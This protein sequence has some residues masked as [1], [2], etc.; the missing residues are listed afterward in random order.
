MITG[1]A[2]STVGCGSEHYTVYFAAAFDH[3][4]TS[5]G[6]WAGRNVNQHATAS[7]SAQSGAFVT[8]GT[9]SIQVLHVQVGLSFVSIANAR[10]NLLAENAN[11]HFDTV[12]TQADAA[13]NAKLNTIQVQGGTADE[14]RVFYT[15]LYHVFLEPSIFSDVNGQYLGFDN[16]VHTVARGHLH[17]QNIPGWD[18]YRS[19]I[20]LLSIIDASDASD[21]AQSL[22]DDATQGDG[23]IPRWVQ[24]N[25]D[26]HGMNGDG[27]SIM[28]AEAYAF[29]AT[30]FDT[31]S[32]L[33]AMLHGQANVR[34]GLQDYLTLGYVANSTLKNATVV[35]QEYTNADFAIAQFARALGDQND[36]A[37]LLHRSGN[38]RNIFNPTSGYIQPRNRDGSWTA[39]FDLASDKSFQEGNSAQYS[40]MESFDLKDLFASMGGNAAVVKRLNTFFTGL[41]VGQSQPYAFIGNEPCFE[42]PWEYDFA[43]APAQTQ[44]VIR[45]IQLRLFINSPDGLPGNDDGGAMSSWYIFSALGIYPEIPGI[46]GFVIGSP[47]FTSATIQLSGD[48]TLQITAPA[49]ADNNEYVQSLQL[50]GHTTTQLWL[51]WSTVQNGATLNF[52]LGSTPTTWG[53]APTDTPPSYT[54]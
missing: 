3:T 27:G 12:R 18:A 54:P 33:S 30:N 9:N 32:A 48:H 7:A 20:R 13:W 36:Y 34:E 25:T 6:T 19:T 26:S 24:A 50:N 14:R 31:T 42:V 21:L 8:F 17:F 37:T 16:M 4:F 35:T 22:V 53:S 2:T 5:W 1:S 28:V 15:S 11:S 43:Q 23:H 10:A 44:N 38:W 39:N 52:A 40:W 46:G 41:N 49:A 45:R 29:G 47:L 51:P